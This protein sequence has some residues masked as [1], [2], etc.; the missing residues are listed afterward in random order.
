MINFIILIN[1]VIVRIT[2]V[3]PGENCIILLFNIIL[4]IYKLFSLHA[5]KYVDGVYYII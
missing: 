4:F 3:R 1:F 2:Y 5:H